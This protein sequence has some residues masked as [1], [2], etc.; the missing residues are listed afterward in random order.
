[1]RVQFPPQN[2]PAHDAEPFVVV[3][4]QSRGRVKMFSGALV[5]SMPPAIAEQLEKDL[6]SARTMPARAAE[7]AATV[8]SGSGA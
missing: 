1:M 7:M 6:K 3:W 5:V 2:T 8:K 4:D